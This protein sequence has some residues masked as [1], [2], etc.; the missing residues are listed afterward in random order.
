MVK[1]IARLDRVASQVAIFEKI[2]INEVNTCVLVNFDD[3]YVYVKTLGHGA[4]GVVKCYREK[5]TSNMFA[6]KEINIFNSTEL[7]TLQSEVEILKEISREIESS[8]IIK[9]HDSFISKSGTDYLFVIVTEYIEGVSLQDYLNEMIKSGEYM[10][11]RTILRI[12][13][14]LFDTLILLHNK[15]Y[16][17]RDIKPNNIMVD[18][19]N[20]RFVLI[21]FG[22][23]CSITA[24]ANNILCTNKQFDGTTIFMAPE[25]WNIT[26]E[27]RKRFS[28][29]NRNKIAYLKLLDI[30]AA[31]VTIYFLTENKAPWT[32]KFSSGVIDQ[33]IGSYEIPY[34]RSRN[35]KDILELALEKNPNRRVHAEYIRDY[36]GYVISNKFF[37]IMT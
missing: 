35:I 29:R 8:S 20:N 12:A 36:I 28:P 7:E 30:W 17:H 31:G 1:S 33:I 10:E 4:S 32:E 2:V 21:D 25:S 16:I 37:D 15:G 18:D 6:M 5:S 26:Q 23:T 22:L 9:Y 3:L 27:T 19:V 11:M 34:E 24:R 13:Y 14:W